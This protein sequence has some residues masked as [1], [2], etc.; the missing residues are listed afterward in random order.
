MLSVALELWVVLIDLCF[1]LHS[2]G[3]A[4]IRPLML[5]APDTKMSLIRQEK[6][7][8]SDLDAID[9]PTCERKE[10]GNKGPAAFMFPSNT[11]RILCN[12][13]FLCI[14]FFF[15]FLI[16]WDD[17]ENVSL[18]S[19]SLTSYWDLWLLIGYTLKLGFNCLLLVIV[20]VSDVWWLS[21]GHFSEYLY[22][23]FLTVLLANF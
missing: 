5:F 10:R 7:L 18:N 12:F 14:F 3:S 23:F 15:F 6:A 4:L 17:W 13:V 9:I 20:I 21:L 22:H 16:N 2:A 1:R 19:Y 11:S 8:S